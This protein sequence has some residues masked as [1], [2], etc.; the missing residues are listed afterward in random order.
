MSASQSMS[1]Y[2]CRC[3]ELPKPGCPAPV[4]AT[5]PSDLATRG[6]LF[7]RGL[8]VMNSF[9]KSLTAVCRWRQSAPY[10]RVNSRLTPWAI[11]LRCF[12]ATG[13]V[14]VLVTLGRVPAQ[15]QHITFR[16]VSA[17]AGIRFVHNNGAFGKKY[18]PETM[19]PGCAF[20]DYDNDGYP[21]I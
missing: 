13:T 3:R 10:S 20:I 18:L 12:V 14:A 16:D 11:F 5:R 9:T 8:Q 15:A 19:G 6:Y 4:P 2:R 1:T 21:D 7:Q 17:Q